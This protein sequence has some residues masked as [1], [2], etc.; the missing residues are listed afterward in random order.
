MNKCYARRFSA[1]IV[2]LLIIISV[3]SFSGCEKSAVSIILDGS[4]IGVISAPASIGDCVLAPADGVFAALGAGCTYDAQTGEIKVQGDVLTASCKVGDTAFTVNGGSYEFSAPPELIDGKPY[5]SVKEVFESAG[6]TVEWDGGDRIYITSPET[7]LEVRFIDVGQADS[8]LLL[9]DGESMLIDGGNVADSD[10][11]YTVLDYYGLDYIDCVVCT[12]AHEDHVGG[13]SA[14]LAK[15]DVGVI[16]APKTTANTKAYSNFAAKAEE[17]GVEITH[18]SF[19]D[20]FGLGGS[21]VTF[22]GPVTE[23]GKDLNNTSVVLKVEYG[24]VSFLFTG[25]AETEEEEEILEAGADVSA[26]VLKV[27]HHGS[28]T[29]TSYVFLREVMPKYAVIS[30]G[31]SNDYGHPHEEVLSRLRDAG[32]KLYR[33]DMQGDVVAVTDGK[34]IEFSTFRNENAEVNTT[35]DKSREEISPDTDDI[36]AEGARFIGNKKTKALHSSDCGNLPKEG[37]RVYFDS[38]EDALAGGY[39]PHKN[40]LGKK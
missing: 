33:T 12:H 26:D 23:D 39:T 3:F 8:A 22:L 28:V 7:G 10:T 2:S 11:I 27:G 34:T 9:C 35:V 19:G 16:Y 24:D 31:K 37:N 5:V 6:Y 38:Y 25:D 36:A 14:A 17:R 21:V 1:L 4:D 29:S 30:V 15:A 18:P 32:V 40:C 20:S 13:L